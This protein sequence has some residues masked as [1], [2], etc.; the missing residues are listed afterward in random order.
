[1]VNQSVFI[2]SLRFRNARLITALLCEHGPGDPRE[3]VGKGR[4]QNIR[5]QALNGTNEPGSKT[6]LRPVRRPQQNNPGCLDEEH[7]K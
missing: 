4:S 2:L 1:M 3:L 6:V 7:A 5:M